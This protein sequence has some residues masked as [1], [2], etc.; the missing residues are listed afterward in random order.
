MVPPALLDVGAR[1]H[2]AA[3]A[4]GARCTRADHVEPGVEQRVERLL[5]ERGKDFTSGTAD[6]HEV[7][8]GHGA[9]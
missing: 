4:V 7:G 2:L 8:D 3:G 1:L 5:D 9:R 6:E